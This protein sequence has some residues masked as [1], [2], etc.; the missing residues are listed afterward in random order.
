V[1]S[2]SSFQLDGG[3]LVAGGN[4]PDAA[5]PAA[6]A[7]GPLEMLSH[8]HARTLQQC[9]SLRQLALGLA[10]RGCD[11]Q[12]SRAAESVLRYFDVC[13]PQYCSDEEDD[14]FPALLESMAGSD[15]VCLRELTSAMAQ[16]HRTLETMWQRLRQPLAA[17]A[18]GG[19][20]APASDSVDLFVALYQSHIE[21]ERIELLP[22]AA[23]LLTD[24]A[25]E[26]VGKS[27]RRRHDGTTRR[28]A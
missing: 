8:L 15:A 17:A 19:G 21:R 9:E 2:P 23:R 24:E 6:Q 22:M 16:Q 13:A 26:Q 28:P 12:A 1:T 14:L 11:E 7:E 25:L 18:S 27:M 5:A 20:A 3:S 4:L 10:E